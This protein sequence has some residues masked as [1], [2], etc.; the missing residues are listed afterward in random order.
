MG[1]L[2]G[3]GHLI[4]IRALTIAPASLLAPFVYTQIAWALLLGYLVFDDVP[5]VWML[6]GGAVIVASGLLRVLP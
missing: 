3:L 6:A 1:A 4:L 5:D 2:G